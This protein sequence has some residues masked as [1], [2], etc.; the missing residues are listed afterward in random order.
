MRIFIPPLGTKVMLS[1][2]WTFTLHPESRNETMFKH[3]G[4]RWPTNWHEQK[5]IEPMSVT[6][7]QGTEL[8]FDRIFIRKGSSDYDSVTFFLCGQK[9]EKETK[10]KTIWAGEMTKD[11]T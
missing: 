3:L 7:P 4:M 8:R 1:E 6:L 5:K 2:P 9:T 11:Y 10:T